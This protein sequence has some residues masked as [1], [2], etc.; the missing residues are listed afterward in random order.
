[1][2]KQQQL[3]AMTPVEDNL[4]EDDSIM[5][6]SAMSSIAN[7]SFNNYIQRMIEKTSQK[8]D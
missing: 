7:E 5:R 2:P 1:M 4:F 3:S 6:T 8:F